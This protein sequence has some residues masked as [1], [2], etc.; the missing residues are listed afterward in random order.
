[1]LFGLPVAGTSSLA[2]DSG[3]DQLFVMVSFCFCPPIKGGSSLV[4]PGE[5][6]L[7]ICSH[8][9]LPWMA[10]RK[11]GQQEVESARSWKL[12]L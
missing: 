1:M 10:A 6:M 4:T 12:K 7:S 9:G 11:G 3:D 8:L 5:S 2:A